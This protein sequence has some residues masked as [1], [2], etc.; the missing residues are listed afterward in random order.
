[1]QADRVAQQNNAPDLPV[2]EMFFERSSEIMPE[3]RADSWCLRDTL[4]VV[5][6]S[7]EGLKS[8]RLV[9]TPEYPGCAMLRQV[10][11]DGLPRSLRHV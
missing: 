6:A 1:M 9:G 7:R 5:S 8:R 4:R 3:D 10:L 2:G 11:L